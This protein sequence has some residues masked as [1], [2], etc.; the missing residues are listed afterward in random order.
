M[1]PPHVSADI[2]LCSTHL[3]LL[4]PN[5]TLVCILASTCN[6]SIT[7]SSSQA[8]ALDNHS[9]CEVD[10][11]FQPWPVLGHPPMGISCSLDMP[12]CWLVGCWLLLGLAASLL[13]C[14]QRS[15]AR[16]WLFGQGT[17][18]PFDQ[19]VWTGLPWIGAPSN[20]K[21]SAVGWMLLESHRHRA[22]RC[23]ILVALE[24]RRPD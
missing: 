13:T 20:W 8:R 22:Q 19:H 1:P 24:T 18:P 3:L 2:V 16:L 15:K 4:Y 14:K 17:I 5:S 11:H 21:V 12:V 10:S 6:L 7:S 9:T 23:T